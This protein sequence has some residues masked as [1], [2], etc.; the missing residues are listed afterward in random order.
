[1]SKIEIKK[2]EQKDVF[3]IVDTF[4]LA[5]A[6]M[7]YLPVVH[8]QIEIKDFFSSLV[9][10]G[11]V[12]IATLDDKIIGFMEIKDGWLNHLYILPNF[13]N[14]GIGTLLLDKAKQLNPKG[15]YLWIFEENEEAI[16]FYEHEGFILKEKRTKEQTNNEEHLPDRRYC[17]S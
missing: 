10:K 11:S 9:K 12:W 1:M 2:A 14:K 7:K 8:T 15:I 5:R 3:L 6:R 13:Q 4:N 17:W 16:K